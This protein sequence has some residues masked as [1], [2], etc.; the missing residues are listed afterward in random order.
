MIR[1]GDAGGTSAAQTRIEPEAPGTFSFLQRHIGDALVVV[2]LLVTAFLARRHSL[3]RDGLWYD[4]AWEA[5]GAA[6]G[7]LSHLLAVSENQPGFRLA[8]MVL[9]RL[10]RNSASFAYPAMIAGT[11]TPAVLYLVLRRFGYTAAVCALL[12]GG[13]VAAQTHIMYSGRV[14]TYV[15]DIL[16]VL[17]LTA[18]I[19]RLARW[20]WRWPTALGWAAASLAIA[21]FGGFA[22]LA[23]TAAGVILV[24]HSSS[25][26]KVRVAAVAAQLA[27]S[28]VLLVTVQRTYNVRAVEHDLEFWDAYPHVDVNPLRSGGEVLKHLSRVATVFPGSGG[29]WATVCAIVVLVGLIA[30]ASTGHNRVRARYLLLLLLVALIGG[31]TKRFPFGPDK[32][33]S[34]SPGGR[35]SLWLVPVM[36]LGIAAVLQCLRGLVKHRP[37]YRVGFDIIS[38]VIVTLVVAAALTRD[39]PTYPFPG[40]KSA[41][42]FVQSQL[43]DSDVALIMN[44]GFSFALESDTAVTMRGQPTEDVGFIPDFADSRLKVLGCSPFGTGCNPRAVYG[45]EVHAAVRHAERV[46]VHNDNP[47]LADA[48]STLGPVWTALRAE[49]FQQGSPISFG[50]ARVW[51]WRRPRAEPHYAQG[52][53]SVQQTVRPAPSPKMSTNEHGRESCQRC[54]QREGGSN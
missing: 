8:L 29:W 14:K 37:A 36:A 42:Q 21:S 34:F 53:P 17:G 44:Q 27:A 39:T 54:G 28:S 10:T 38:L 18:V 33:Q 24:V 30:T 20:R 41:T 9:Y 5:A 46:L 3:P 47:D 1:V 13:L 25:D 6:K 23:A 52:P 15:F 32:V 50:A 48:L 19:P 11:L 51:V 35:W 16:I 26:W 40:S 45:P 22:F 31:I 2:L 12:A 7:S 49:G 4:D 43:R